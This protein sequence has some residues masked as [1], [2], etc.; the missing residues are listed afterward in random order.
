[1]LTQH[2]ARHGRPA[3]FGLAQEDCGSH[4]LF[5]RGKVVWCWQGS[6]APKV[7]ALPDSLFWASYEIGL[8]VSGSVLRIP[9]TKTQTK[10]K[11]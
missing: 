5:R 4:F 1:M 2:D 11:F 10:R 7:S 8:G 6:R 9:Q 3:P